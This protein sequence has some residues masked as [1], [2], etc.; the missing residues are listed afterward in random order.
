MKNNEKKKEALE[1]FKVI[2]IVVATVV[3]LTAVFIACKYYLYDYFQGSELP[4]LVEVGASCLNLHCS[5]HPQGYSKSYIKSTGVGFGS[6]QPYHM[7]VF[8]LSTS[9]ALRS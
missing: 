7:Y 4:R 1:V 2:S 3:I 6:F 9:E 8:R 5:G